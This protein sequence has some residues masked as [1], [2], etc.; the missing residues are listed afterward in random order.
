MEVEKTIQEKMKLVKPVE[1]V[2]EPMAKNNLFG[3]GFIK[4]IVN[5]VK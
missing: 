3:F 1:Y 4:N 5:N 2:E